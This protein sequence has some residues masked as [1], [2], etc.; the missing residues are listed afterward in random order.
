MQLNQDGAELPVEGSGKKMDRRE[1]QAVWFLVAIVGL[2]AAVST[3]NHF[4]E[5]HIRATPL[6][7]AARAGDMEEVL[8]L[9]NEGAEVNATSPS[10]YTALHYAAS[11]GHAD[12]VRLLLRHGADPDLREAGAEL[13]ILMSAAKQG[14]VEVVKA[15]LEG[16]AKPGRHSFGRT[17]LFEAGANNQQEVARLLEHYGAQK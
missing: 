5:H 3:A 13:T 16:G 17:A 6:M 2:F 15:L 14:R 8:R 11:K 10:G 9:L 1:R 12:L 4:Y 7:I